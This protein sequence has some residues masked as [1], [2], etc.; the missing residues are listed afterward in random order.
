MGGF[1]SGS[2]CIETGAMMVAVQ[3]AKSGAQLTI[4]SSV[5]LVA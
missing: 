3:E 2:Q 1:C 4:A 5:T